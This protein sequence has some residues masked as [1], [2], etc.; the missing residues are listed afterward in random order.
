MWQRFSLSPPIYVRFFLEKCNTH[1]HKHTFIHTHLHIHTH[2]HHTHTH[3]NT[4]A[5]INTHTHIFTHTH[6]DVLEGKCLLLKMQFVVLCDK[7]WDGC[8]TSSSI[9]ELELEREREREREEGKKLLRGKKSFKSGENL[10]RRL[11]W[12]RGN[13]KSFIYVCQMWKV[14]DE[15]QSF[16]IEH[17]LE[18]FRCKEFIFQHLNVYD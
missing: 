17:C 12:D 3:K 14:F 4:C 2:I 16:S 9:I 10:F 11:H 6:T 1:T 15:I 7:F 18:Q 13:S 5:R 8:D